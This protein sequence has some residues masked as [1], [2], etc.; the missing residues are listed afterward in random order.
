MGLTGEVLEIKRVEVDG[1][2]LLEVRADC[3]GHELEGV[4]YQAPGLDAPP[5]ADDL[6]VMVETAR[7]VDGAAVGYVDTVN[8]GKA[9]AGEFRVY[10]RKAD[11][12]IPC[13]IYL[14]KDGSIVVLVDDK[15][16]IGSG[17]RK[18]VARD[19][20]EVKI[21]TPAEVPLPAGPIN[22]FAWVAAV[23]TILMTL[24]AGAAAAT[25]GGVPPTGLTGKVQA[26]ATKLEVQ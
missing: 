1:R 21:G 22:L 3:A 9:E 17:S 6:V 15:F 16:Y 20:D 8:A 10:A 13:E 2:K 19:Q 14:K 18:K 26:T 24:T 5:L 4:A 25:L 23:H 11:G 12:S 7:N